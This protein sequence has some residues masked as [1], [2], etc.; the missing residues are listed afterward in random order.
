[1]S[2]AA[3]PSYVC[4][5]SNPPPLRPTLTAASCGRL[6]AAQR[7]HQPYRTPTLPP[8]GTQAAHLVRRSRAARASDA[9][10]R[11]TDVNRR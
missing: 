10:S 7:R 9:N 8:G 6:S 5:P 11:G 3:M 4:E 1:M 2:P